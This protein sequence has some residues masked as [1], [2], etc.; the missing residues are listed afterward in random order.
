MMMMGGGGGPL[1]ATMMTRNETM[2]QALLAKC[3]WIDKTIWVSR[4]LLG[5]NHNNGFLFATSNVQRIKRQRARQAAQTHK[6]TTGKDDNNNNNLVGSPEHNT[7]DTSHHSHNN[8]NNNNE[9][10]PDGGKEGG[11]NKKRDAQDLS[12]EETLKKEVMN[13]RTAKKLRAELEMGV[14]FCLSLQNTIRT[15]LQQ[16]DPE[17]ARYTPLPLELGGKIP[18]TFPASSSANNNNHGSRETTTTTTTT[19]ATKQPPAS[20]LYSSN[21]VK[22]PSST[23]TA[24]TTPTATSSA[25][26]AVSSRSSNL[27]LPGT[28]KA[29]NMLNPLPPASTTTA[30][31]ASHLTK[32][33]QQVLLSQR[34]A[35]DASTSAVG[36]NNNKKTNSTAAQASP[37]GPGGSTLR[38]HRKKKFTP[39]TQVVLSEFDAAGK[40]TCSKKEYGFRL[41]EAIRFR[42]LKEGDFV[43]AR[44]SSRDLWILARVQTDFPGFSMPAADFLNLT[45]ARRDATFKDKVAIKDVEDKDGA[46]QRVPRS[47]VL[48]LPRTYSE[49]AE[50]GQRYVRTWGNK[51]MKHC[52]CV[53]TVG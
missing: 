43:A 21:S 11:G 30:S 37:G 13:P 5:G 32:Q 26:T 14:Q 3:D 12:V 42:A 24:T 27:I 38:K 48:P 2:T 17:I 29:S 53:A 7:K 4:Q 34:R 39:S 1:P 8:S 47:L 33:Q 36:N 16:M 15:I 51:F 19:Y 18:T 44:V 52:Q 22:V 49:A 40:R 35:S 23:A 45:E 25:S 20:S 31:A 50:W 46:T 41:F 6:K 28:A 10:G 9:S